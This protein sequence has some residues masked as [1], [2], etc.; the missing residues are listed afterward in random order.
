MPDLIFTAFE[1][2]AAHILHMIK[3]GGREFP[4]VGTDFDGFGGM[5]HMDIPNISQMR[6]LWEKLKEKGVSEDQ[7][8]LIWGGN[9]LRVLKTLR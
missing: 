3:I 5:E 1:E 7:L 8:D 2:M 6:R 4:A 9:A